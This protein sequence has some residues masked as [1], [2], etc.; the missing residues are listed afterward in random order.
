MKFNFQ[1]PKA[2]EVTEV[3]IVSEI[4]DSLNGII[5][6]LGI[7][8]NLTTKQAFVYICKA[9]GEIKNEEGI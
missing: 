1:F 8:E 4:K 7:H 9:L 6:S 5:G 2:K 3:K